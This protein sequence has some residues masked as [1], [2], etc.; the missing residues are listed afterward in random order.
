MAENEMIKTQ[1]LTKC[2]GSE[3]ARIIAVDRLNINVHKGEIFGFLGSNGSG[4]TTVINMLLGLT[5][6]TSGSIELFGYKANKNLPNILKKVGFVFDS[7]SLFKHLSGRNNLRYFVMKM[8]GHINAG[9]IDELIEMMGLKGRGG[10]KVKGYS[11]GMKQRL[12]MAVALL[13]DPEL[14]I[15][16]ESANGLD[17][18]GIIDFRRLIKSLHKQGKTILLSSHLLHEAEQVCTH[19]A[20]MDKGRLI[21]SGPLGNFLGNKVMTELAVSHADAA[22][23]AL[24]GLNWIKSVRK[25]GNLVKVETLDDNS[26]EINRVL[27]ENGIAV[28][29]IKTRRSSLE[30]FYQ[31]ALNA[32]GMACLGLEI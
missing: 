5:K 12:A 14:V 1:E 30:D 28:K 2:Y 19:V 29:E 6:P 25:K 24:R 8:G 26:S 7:P 11:L 10:E 4:K 27:T 15:L 18:A 23:A 13:N 16:D 20:L 32:D 9:R 31:T 21:S 22:I 3:S 17:P